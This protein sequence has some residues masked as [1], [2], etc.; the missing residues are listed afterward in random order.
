MKYD[1]KFDSIEEFYE[2]AQKPLDQYQHIWNRYFLDDDQ[3]FRG[4][5]RDR[6]MNELKYNYPEGIEKIEK[7][8][9]MTGHTT[10]AATIRTW[11]PDDGDDGD[12]ERYLM[13]L[14]H[15]IRRKKVL[16][17]GQRA[18]CRVIVSLCESARIDPQDLLYKTYAASRIV[19]QLEAQGQRCEV[20][21]YDYHTDCEQKT[22]EPYKVQVTLKRADDPLNIGLIATAL[23]PWFL[24]HW[25]FSH[26]FGIMNA[27]YGLGWAAGV[28]PGDYEEGDILINK[29]ECLSQY[30]AEEKIRSLDLNHE[31]IPA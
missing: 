27:D 28:Q 26:I 17:Q 31:R 9:G 8:P 19:D 30:A 6:I 21:A 22:R 2:A 7:L 13:E 12:Y 24:R 5:R 15:M 3:K 25:C 16:R 14:P 20:I 29:G 4:A 18:V 1:Y 10:Q 23:S 11:H